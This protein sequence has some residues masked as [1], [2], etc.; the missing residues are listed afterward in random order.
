VAV[1]VSAAACAALVTAPLA[2][3]GTQAAQMV[4]RGGRIKLAFHAF[5][6]SK[7]DVAVIIIYD[8]LGAVLAVLALILLGISKPSPLISYFHSDPLV[9]WAIFGMVGPAFAIAFL[10]RVPVIRLAELSSPNSAVVSEPAQKQI[11]ATVADGVALRRKSVERIFKCHYE[12]L[13][14]VEEIERLDLQRR[15]QQLIRRGWLHF[16]DVARQIQ[17]YVR[18]H[19]DGE[20]PAHIAE[21]LDRRDSWPVDEDLFSAG[22]SLVGITLDAGLTRPINIACRV[23]ESIGERGTSTDV[24]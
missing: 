4:G 18:E 19:R 21:A 1:E 13:R 10:D 16:D 3:L 23:A 6:R 17:D 11:S 24:A 15:A 22:L 5:A 20:M 14:V 8:V 7:G 12:D 2:G 9:A